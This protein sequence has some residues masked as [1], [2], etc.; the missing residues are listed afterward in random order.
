MQSSPKCNTQGCFKQ[1]ILDFKN[2]KVKR[3]K[4]TVSNVLNYPNYPYSGFCS[5]SYFM[6]S[7]RPS[8]AKAI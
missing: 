5:S 2:L 8:V 4:R 6:L 3:Y 1:V 7:T